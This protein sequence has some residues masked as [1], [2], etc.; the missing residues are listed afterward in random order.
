MSKWV[1]RFPFFRE[2]TPK[3]FRAKIIFGDHWVKPYDNAAYQ[4]NKTM[5]QNEMGS[6][7]VEGYRNIALV[8]FSQMDE[9]QKDIYQECLMKYGKFRQ[10]FLAYCLLT[11][12]GRYPTDREFGLTERIRMAQSDGMSIFIWSLLDA[13]DGFPRDYNIQLRFEDNSEATKKYDAEEE[14][15]EAYRLG[16]LGAYIRFA[17]NFHRTVIVARNTLFCNTLKKIIDES[18]TSKTPTNLFSFIGFGH[19]GMLPMLPRSWQPVIQTDV[20]TTTHYVPTATDRIIDKL[21]R[22]RKVTQDEWM[23]GYQAFFRQRPNR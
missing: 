18:E 13:L 14:M 23:Q 11:G 19:A 3:Y 7:F 16:T 2:P 5:L 1:E 20:R 4:A 9:G 6:V 10:A 21:S 17:N 22:G 8:E 15:S 12:E